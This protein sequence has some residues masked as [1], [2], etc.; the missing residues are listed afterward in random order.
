MSC[1]KTYLPPVFKDIRN[2]KITK[3]EKGVVNMKADAIL[4]NPNDVSAKL[5]SIDI[6]VFIKD[7][8]VAKIKENYSLK[9]SRLSEFSVPLN[10]DLDLSNLGLINSLLGFIQGKQFDA[11]YVGKAKVM[12]HGVPVNIPI[13]YHEVL[14]LR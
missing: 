9:I 7:Q 5:K 10:L 8:K 4:Y 3:G 13:D 6:E 11:H 2:A 12:M 14:K 1:K